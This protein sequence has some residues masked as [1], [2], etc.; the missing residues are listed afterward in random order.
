MLINGKMRT[1]QIKVKFNDLFR[2]LGG[3]LLQLNMVAGR[4]WSLLLRL[5]EPKLLGGDHSIKEY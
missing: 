3:S 2:T 1:M 5:K 4:K